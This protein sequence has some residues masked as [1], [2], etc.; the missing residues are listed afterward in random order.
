MTKEDMLRDY[1]LSKYTNIAQF[2]KQADIPKPTMSNVFARGV[3]NCS[4]GTMIKI[5]TTLGIDLTK[6]YKEGIIVKN[7]MGI[8]DV[9]AFDLILLTAYHEKKDVQ[10]AVNILLGVESPLHHIES[11]DED[12]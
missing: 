6:L 12:K 10:N 3:D 8:E 9:S 7:T 11:T 1:I 4:I 2:C 5:C